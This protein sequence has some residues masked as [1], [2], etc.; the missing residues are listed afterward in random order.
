MSENVKFC[1]PI[2][3]LSSSSFTTFSERCKLRVGEDICECSSA[4]TAVRD[5]SRTL[6]ARPLV[7][8][9]CKFRD[10]AS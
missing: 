1:H 10:Y 9:A 5:C 4:K 8:S 3:W 2:Y 7:H 6:R